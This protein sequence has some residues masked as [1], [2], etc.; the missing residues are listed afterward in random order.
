MSN[1]KKEEMVKVNFAIPVELRN[2]AHALANL[3]DD[4]KGW[5]KVMIDFMKTGAKVLL[6]D[7]KAAA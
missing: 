4:P 6:P 7:Q 5:R 1:E 3:R 2:K